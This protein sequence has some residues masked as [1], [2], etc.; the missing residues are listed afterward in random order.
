MVFSNN[1]SNIEIVVVVEDVVLG[2]V[3]AVL[4]ENIA[5]CVVKI[6]AGEG[7]VLDVAGMKKLLIT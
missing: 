6:A 1:S 2:L 7:E 4:E 3:S 5:C